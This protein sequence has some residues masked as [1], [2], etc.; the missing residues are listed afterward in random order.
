MYVWVDWWVNKWEVQG[1]Y[2]Q[3]VG[4]WMEVK[5]W[6]GGECGG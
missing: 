2:K 5:K 4:R 1:R 6:Y 3:C